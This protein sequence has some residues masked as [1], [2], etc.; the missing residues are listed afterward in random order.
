MMSAQLSSRTLHGRCPCT[1][2]GRNPKA[3]QGTRRC[4]RRRTIVGRRRQAMQGQWRRALVLLLFRAM[5]AMHH[6]FV[7]DCRR[8][9][10][11][12]LY[13]DAPRSSSAIAGANQ[14]H[15]CPAKHWHWPIRRSR[16]NALAAMSLV[17]TPKA[18]RQTN[19]VRPATAALRHQQTAPCYRKSRRPPS[20][21]LL[22]FALT[23]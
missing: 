17:D 1:R 23:V 19:S 22:S 11:N 6:P 2:E 18:L 4:R 12:H 14:S 13:L 21:L 10:C 16:P 3:D 9:Q 15:G 8:P 7:L 20:L 5:A